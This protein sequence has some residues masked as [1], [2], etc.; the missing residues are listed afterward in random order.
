[1]WDEVADLFAQKTPGVTAEIADGGVWEGTEGI[2]R[3]FPG[4]HAQMIKG[5]SGNLMQHDLTTPVI[6]IAGDGKTA[7]GLWNS[8]GVLTRREATGELRSVWIWVK[9]GCDFVQEDG[10]W[11]IWH[12]QVYITFRTPFDEGWAKTPIVSSFTGSQEFRPDSELS[13][14]Y[15][16]YHPDRINILRPA[17]PE[18]YE[19]WVDGEG[20]TGLPKK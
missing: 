19:T 13:T 16:P 7:K 10:K 8:P 15:R 18:P 12:F 14:Y 9:Y 17:P 3:L 1:M 5:R 6:E 20:M 2:K 11:K 4:L